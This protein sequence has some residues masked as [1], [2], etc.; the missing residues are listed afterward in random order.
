VSSAIPAAIDYLVNLVT[1]LPVCAQ[2]VVS[3]GYS[4]VAAP[5]GMVLVGVDDQTGETGSTNVW[6]ALGNTVQDE[7]FDIPL[8]IYIPSGNSDAK[9]VRDTAFGVYD[10]IRE[11]VRADKT[12]GGVLSPPG[13]AQLTTVR[14]SQTNTAEE[15]STGRVARIYITVHCTHRLQ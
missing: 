10:A 13:I 5:N 14:L 12:L 15:G 2:M 9:G 11:A 1:A 7:T 6:A 3:D 4:P 8:A